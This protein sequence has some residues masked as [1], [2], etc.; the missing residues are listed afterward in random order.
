MA[1]ETETASEPATIDSIAAEYNLMP[2]TQT[3][4]TEPSPPAQQVAPQALVTDSDGLNKWAAEQTQQT[5]DLRTTLDNTVNALNAEK[6]H[7]SAQREE[8][9][10]NALIGDVSKQL[11]GV[12]DKMVKYALADRYNSDPAFKAIL[13]N[14][15]KAPKAL[16]RAI[17][18]LVP[19]LRSTFAIKADPQIAENQRAMSEGTRGSSSTPANANSKDRELLD[20]NSSEFQNSWEMIKAGG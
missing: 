8:Q 18:A 12:P 7:L 14:R 6:Q 20:M 3:Q 9:E 4:Q 16:E 17:E 19:D 11:D 1:D 5:A 13:D 15:G 10:L 2:E